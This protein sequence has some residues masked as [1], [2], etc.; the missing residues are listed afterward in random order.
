VLHQQW[1]EGSHILAQSSV[2]LLDGFF[3]DVGEGLLWQF[4]LLLQVDLVNLVLSHHSLGH[5]EEHLDGRRTIDQVA[6][7]KPTSEVPRE[8][9]DYVQNSTAQRE[10]SDLSQVYDSD[11]GLHLPLQHAVLQHVAE[12]VPRNLVERLLLQVQLDYTGDVDHDDGAEVDVAAHQVEES[13]FLGS[14][15]AYQDVLD[16][17]AETERENGVF[18]LLVL[19][20]F[21]GAVLD[22]ELG[23]LEEAKQRGVGQKGEMAVLALPAEFIMQFHQFVLLEGSVGHFALEDNAVNLLAAHLVDLLVLGEEEE[24]LARDQRVLS[25]HIPNVIS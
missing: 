12:E 14:S 22:V 21:F 2:L 7:V 9:G 16:F 19:L 25:D 15:M 10:H 18:P 6:V 3:K 23:G 5:A 20:E 24:G 8:E 17:R 11:P 13:L 4:C 1:P